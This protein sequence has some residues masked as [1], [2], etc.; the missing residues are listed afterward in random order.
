MG[1]GHVK[2]RD[3]VR[4]EEGRPHAQA[5]LDR[6]YPRGL[7]MFGRAT[8]RREA[9]YQHW[10]LKRRSIETARTEYVAEVA[11]LIESLG[12]T[13]PDAAADRHFR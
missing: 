10:G 13:V 3:M 4:T 5:A 7:D 1:Y 12:L 9:R 8:S 6:W 11:P 2:L